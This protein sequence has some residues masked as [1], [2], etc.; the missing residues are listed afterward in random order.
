MNAEKAGIAVHCQSSE[1]LRHYVSVANETNFTYGRHRVTWKDG[2]CTRLKMVYKYYWQL[3]VEANETERQCRLCG[4]PSA[5]TLQHYVL[6]CSS[7]AQYRCDQPLSVT[8]QII[9]MF[10]DGKVMDLLMKHKDIK[11]NIVNEEAV[12]F[13]AASIVCNCTL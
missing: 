11:K 5:H 2:V 3:G 12:K 8:D 4:E 6:H 9:C 1:T 10:N 13:P 7:L